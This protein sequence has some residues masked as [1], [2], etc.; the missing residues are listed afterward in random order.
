[1]PRTA[2][3][4]VI[5]LALLAPAQPPVQAQA[6]SPARAERELRQL[7]QQI[8]KVERELR[9]ET[10]QRGG[11]ER[12]LRMAEQA[13]QA[14]R[15]RLEQLSGEQ[16]TIEQR[17]AELEQ[18]AAAT[19]GELA[20]HQQ[21]LAA[22]L[23]ARHRQGDQ[24]RLR[25]LLGGDDAARLGR[26]LTW[27]DAVSRAQLTL[28][29]SIAGQLDQLAA[30]AAALRA[31]GERLAALQKRQQDELELLAAA[32]AERARLLAAASADV[33]G[34]DTELA[35]LRAE[36]GQLEK[37]LEQLRQAVARAPAVQPVPGTGPFAQARK[38][39]LWP[40]SGPLLAEYGRPRADGQLRWDGILIGAESGSE[41][42]AVYHGTLVY[43]D[44]LPGL[45]LLAVVDHGGGYLSL[46]GHNQALLR[47]V[48]S[49][50]APGD[51]IGQAGDSGGQARSA[52][53]FEI[54]KDGRPVNPRD[55][56]P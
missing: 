32:R 40:L 53:Y 3:L 47:E 20:R 48:G 22:Q 11:A 19:R 15:R 30:T 5:F 39:I 49:R 42:R 55:W 35:R 23:R 52:L 28:L 9:R 12:A 17:Q 34:R 43:A 51:V 54:R 10:E 1:M 45:G 36:A 29:E 41:V 16:R 33:A 56:L 6:Q 8:Q 21:A 2:L 14:A 27:Y 50:V 46:Y 38:R 24:T 44:W 25:L 37:L 13:E 26:Q 4:L 7:R 31:E 18:S